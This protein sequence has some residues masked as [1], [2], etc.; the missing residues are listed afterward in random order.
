VQLELTDALQHAMLENFV[1]AL[2]QSSQMYYYF[3]VV[4]QVARKFA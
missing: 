1:A 2:Q 4:K 3:A